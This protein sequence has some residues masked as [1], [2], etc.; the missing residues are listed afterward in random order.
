MLLELR[1]DSP[2]YGV[3]SAHDI[4][5]LVEGDRALASMAFLQTAW[6][7]KPIQQLG[8]PSL[9]LDLDPYTARSGL[10]DAASRWR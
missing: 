9:G 4:L 3:S 2:G 8:H 5:K 7:G 6:Q 10:Y 1:A